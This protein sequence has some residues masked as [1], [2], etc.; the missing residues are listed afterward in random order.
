MYIPIDETSFKLKA[1]TVTEMRHMLPPCRV[2]NGSGKVHW[3]DFNPFSGQ[4]LRYLLY[5][6]VGI[7]KSYQKGK[8]TLD[9]AALRK[10][11]LWALGA[12]RE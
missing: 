12:R 5:E 11:R 7:P 3:Y 9:E 4:Q 10:A 2:C 8:E 1:P 6:C